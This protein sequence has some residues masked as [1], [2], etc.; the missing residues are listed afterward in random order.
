MDEIDDQLGNIAEKIELALAK[1]ESVEKSKAVK[2]ESMSKIL[3]AIIDDNADMDEKAKKLRI[4][5]MVQEELK[6]LEMN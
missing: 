3:D 5:A 2:Y 1:M 6:K 4:E